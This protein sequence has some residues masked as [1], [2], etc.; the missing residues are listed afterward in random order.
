MMT[1][2]TPKTAIQKFVSELKPL[3]SAR[4]F[5][6]NV[7]LLWQ[8]IYPQRVSSMSCAA[9]I[10]RYIPYSISIQ[11]TTKIVMKKKHVNKTTKQKRLNESKYSTSQRSLASTTLFG[12]IPMSSQLA[13]MEFLKG[14]RLSNTTAT[15]Y[16][17]RGPAQIC[18]KRYL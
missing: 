18:Q 7:A 1:S 8:S 10:S 9:C 13:V 5:Y 17:E 12:G 14:P 3:A 15:L 4:T 6:M 2:V 16:P 11:Y